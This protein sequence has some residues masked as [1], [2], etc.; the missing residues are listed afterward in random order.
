MVE[1]D[2][3]VFEIDCE[4][5]DAE[6]T[7]YHNGKA[8]I[9]KETEVTTSRFVIIKEGKKRKLIIKD[10]LMADAGDITVKTNKDSSSCKLKVACKLEVN[11]LSK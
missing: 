11:R 8:I 10:T 1:H 3:C 5:E 7:W 9:I 2:Q 6:V 4:A